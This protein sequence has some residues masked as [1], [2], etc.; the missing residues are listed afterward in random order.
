MPGEVGVNGT[1]PHPRARSLA[2]EL[3]QRGRALHL[4][5][6]VR[7]EARRRICVRIDQ[8]DAKLA[9]PPDDGVRWRVHEELRR[10]PGFR[11]DAGAASMQHELAAAVRVHGHQDRLRRRRHDRGSH[12]AAA[13][14][15]IPVHHGERIAGPQRS[16]TDARPHYPDVPL[17]SSI[18]A[19]ASALDEDVA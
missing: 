2:R 17:R 18:E 16:L 12:P 6:D 10:R 5:A 7:R 8:G 1:T 14:R 3:G 13:A 9:P 11:R 4:H 19:L 15:C